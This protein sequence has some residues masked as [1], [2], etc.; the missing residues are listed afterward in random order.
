MSSKIKY[1]S[2]YDPEFETKK[3]QYELLEFRVQKRNQYASK[4]GLKGEQVDE[5]IDYDVKIAKEPDL[6][7]KKKLGIAK[8]IILNILKLEY[9]DP[10]NGYK[11]SEY[12]A[13]KD[14]LDYFKQKCES[15][16]NDNKSLRNTV[17]K[18]LLDSNENKSK[19]IVFTNM[20]K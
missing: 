10:D 6:V 13:M 12:V 1:P 17:N 2:K 4:H 11:Y 8:R 19:K 5:L 9:I 3:A 16:E 7:E 14:S 18:Y 15:L 20:K